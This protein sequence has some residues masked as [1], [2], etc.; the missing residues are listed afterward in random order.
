ML[1]AKPSATC[2]KTRQSWGRLKP[3]S[4]H[5]T[6]RNQSLKSLQRN[7]NSTPIKSQRL[8]IRKQI[9]E[10]ECVQLNKRQCSNK[11]KNTWTQREKMLRCPFAISITTL[12]VKFSTMPFS[13][14]RNTNTK[15]KETKLTNFSIIRAKLNLWLTIFCRG[16]HQVRWP[17]SMMMKNQTEFT[18]RTHRVR[19]INKSICIC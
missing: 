3:N 19:H 9:S 13:Y 8:K 2:S 15:L 6:G 11:C 7:S 18:H 1:V 4:N 17:S 14:W 5:V 12:S 10:R 16:F